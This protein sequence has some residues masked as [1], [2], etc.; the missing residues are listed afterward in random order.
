[1][2]IDA[3]LRNGTWKT[4]LIGPEVLAPTTYNPVLGDCPS[5]TLCVATNQLLVT[6]V[7]SVLDAYVDNNGVWTWSTMPLPPGPS[8]FRMVGITCKVGSRCVSVGSYFPS[9]AS[10]TGSGGG[11]VIEMRSTTGWGQPRYIIPQ[12]LYGALYSISCPTASYCAAV[13]WEQVKSQVGGYLSFSMHPLVAV[14]NGDT[15]AFTLLPDP[16]TNVVQG[17]SS[18]SCPVAGYCVATGM[19]HDNTTKATRALVGTLRSGTWSTQVLPVAAQ[20]F[21]TAT[22]ILLMPDSLA[23]IACVSV[24]RCVAVQPTDTGTG[25]MTEIYNGAT[26]SY[27]PVPRLAGEALVT[28]NSIQCF[29]TIRCYAVGANANHAV[30]G[31]M[32]GTKWSR[33]ILNTAAPSSYA[34]LHGIS[35]GTF[36]SCVAVGEYSLSAHVTAP[37]TAKMV[38]GVWFTG[39]MPMQNSPWQTRAD[40]DAEMWGVSCST[41]ASCTAA[42]YGSSPDTALGLAQDYY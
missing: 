32:N 16:S 12:G 40:Q 8:D 36:S 15:W 29:S 41:A 14:F 13:G 24:T 2:F 33:L 26:W 9:T 34:R 1:L 10:V 21:G 35:C 31:I 22:A 18:V 17:F 38:N 4:Q 6:R 28:L 42:G 11:P 37:F 39:P 30:V 27:I 7:T 5:T 25:T 20:L 19:Y 23:G 3:Q